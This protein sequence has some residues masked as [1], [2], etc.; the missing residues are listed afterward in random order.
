MGVRKLLVVLVILAG[1]LCFYVTRPSTIHEK[2]GGEPAPVV[3]QAPSGLPGTVRSLPQPLQLA[4]QA[5][6]IRTVAR[7]RIPRED[8][9]PLKEISPWLPKAQV[10]VEDKRFYSH[11][12]VDLEGVVRATLVNIQN[13]EVVEGGSTIT[14]QLVK[15][16]LLTSDQTMARKA[17]EMGLAFIVEARCSKE[18]IL[19]MYLNTTF[20]G[21]G[22]T[23]VKQASQVY[24][25][26]KPKDLSLPQAA[27]LAGL[28]YAPTALNPYNNWRGAKKRRNLVLQRMYEQQMITDTQLEEATSE[29][30]EIGN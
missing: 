30:L 25:G 1:A 20:L 13:D 12:G 21:A 5:W 17:A 29:P 23:G 11:H 10:A 9:V 24:F 28:P 4:Y 16:L 8:W 6:N 7:Q 2:V 14:Q 19:E 18:E 27:M 26:K 15:N 3:T 22:A